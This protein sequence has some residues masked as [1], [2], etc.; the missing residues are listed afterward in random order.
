MLP[1]I[2]LAH[3]RTLPK[4]IYTF[5][6]ANL[7]PLLLI[8]ISS[9]IGLRNYDPGKFLSGWDTLHPE[10]NFN[11]YWPRILDSVWQSHQGLGAVGSQAHAAEIPRMI[12]MEF[13]HLFM[14]MDQLR[15]GFAFLMLVIGPLGIFYFVRNIILKNL[16]KYQAELGAFAAGIMYLLNLGTLQHFYVPLEMF[17]VHY[18]FIGW[19]FLTATRFFETGSKRHILAFLLFSVLIIPQAHTPTLFFAFII[20]FCAFYGAVIFFLILARLFKR[21]F[22]RLRPRRVIDDS[23]SEKRFSLH[24]SRLFILIFLTLLVNSFWLMPNVYFL[25]NHSSSIKQSK[26]HHLFSEE[27]FLQNKEFGTVRDVA[28]LRNFLFNWG[29]HVGNGEMGPLMDEWSAHLRRPYVLDIGYGLFA[30]VLLG[31]GLSFLGKNKYAYGLLAVFLI[32]LFF[33]FND[34]PPLGFIFIYLQNN[35]SIFKEGFRFPFTKFSILLI[36]T[37]SVYFGIFI[38]YIGKGIEKIFKRDSL[39]LTLYLYMYSLLLITFSYYMLPAL[40]GHLISPSM[41]VTIPS[42][43][44]EM[45]SYLEKQKE[46][47]RVANLPIQSF[48]GWVYHDWDPSQHLGYQGAGFLWF[49]IK[50]PLLDREFDRWNITNEQYY[51]EMSLAIYSEDVTLLENV[52][53]KFKVRWI[54]LDESIISPG[55]E[56][57]LMFYPQIKTLLQSSDRFTLDVDFGE[58]LKLFK[59]TPKSDFTLKEPLNSFVYSSDSIFKEYGDPIYA[60]Y[61]NYVVSNSKNYP[62]LGITNFDESIESKYVSSDEENTYFTNRL[63]FAKLNVPTIDDTVQYYVSVKKLSGVDSDYVLH[64]EDVPGFARSKVFEYPFKVSVEGDVVLRLGD[65]ILLLPREQLKEDEFVHVGFVQI[66]P[67]IPLA[68]EVLA[69]KQLEIV[70]A[71]IITKLER[72]SETG[73]QSSYEVTKRSN[74]FTLSA[75][76]LD[77]C[78]TLN[79]WDMVSKQELTSTVLSLNV[80]ALG[81]GSEPTV[82]ILDVS[83]G[84]CINRPLVDGITHGFV[85][86]NNQYFVRFSS[87]GT[88][89][90]SVASVTYDD[91][92][93]S[94]YQEL[95]STN[96]DVSP[97]GGFEGEFFGRLTFK[98][99]IVYSGNVTTLRYDPRICSNGQREL[100][101][102]RASIS[103]DAHINYYSKGDSLCDSYQFP[104]ADHSSGHILEVTARNVSGIPLRICLTNEYSKRCDL[105]V[106]LGES[107]KYKTHY[108]LVPPMGKGKGYTVNISNMVFGSGVSENDLEYISLTPFPYTFLRNVHN[109]VPGSDGENLLVYNQAFEPGWIALCGGKICDAPHVLVNNWANG[110]IFPNNYDTNDVKVVF[111]PQALQYIGFILFIGAFISVRYFRREDYDI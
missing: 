109:D 107:K 56:E 54:L 52:C 22:Y 96:L 64:L 71:D 40:N 65:S 42:R 62:Y 78:V 104:F 106:S 58:G 90:N 102:T 14:Q 11:I 97:L 7:V 30:M 79:L 100:G 95:L 49:G 26:I 24:F 47:G 3:L 93:I 20:N 1:F 98:K 81:E 85:D 61:G 63:T 73:E 8:F 41:R 75:S 69:S 103:D 82:C 6:K 18:G 66:V 31:L 110:W 76:G 39:V 10:F 35:L 84:L 2:N 29:E 44:F 83:T 59:Y 28:I 48:W 53:E 70:P 94:T 111:L 46:Y 55:S 4:D 23:D 91:I 89:K 57:T 45:F 87:Q 67:T 105:Y 50:Q 36:M 17:L 92:S 74:G 37:Y 27:A 101:D 34:N 86:I 99:D 9:I 33:L 15:F 21:V 108:F 80:N 5:S 60:M 77:A 72:C 43:Y 19:V 16:P 68:F 51:R 25:V 13:L 38:S 32:C 88:L 12:V